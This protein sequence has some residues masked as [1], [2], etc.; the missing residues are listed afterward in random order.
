LWKKGIPFSF[1]KMKRSSDA[2]HGALN[3]V[4][5]SP[6]EDG[7]VLREKIR[8]T[9]KRMAELEKQNEQFRQISR[10][11]EETAR[12]RAMKLA[13][14][15]NALRQTVEILSDETS[16]D[17]ALG[18]VLKV[19]STFM[20]SSLSALWLFNGNNTSHLRLVCADGEII[21]A[22]P[23][24]T[25]RLKREWPLESDPYLKANIGIPRPVLYDVDTHSHLTAREKAQLR[26]QKIEALLVVPLKLGVEIF[27]NFTICF[28]EK[29]IFNGDE[30][31]LLEAFGAQATLACQL[32][33]LAASSQQAAVLEE[34]SRI[35]GEIHDSLAQA[36]TGISMQLEAALLSRNGGEQPYW[37]NVEMAKDMASFGL[38]EARSSVLTLRPTALD[39][40]D[41]SA[42]L[43]RL[44]ERTCIEGKLQCEFVEKG[45]ARELPVELKHEALRIVQEALGNAL[46]HAHPKIIQITLAYDRENI[47][48]TIQDDGV[49]FDR[50]HSSE[51]RGFG[52]E[53]MADRARKLKGTSSIESVK[54]QGTTVKVT[55]PT[56]GSHA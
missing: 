37:K 23:A 33:R 4:G 55:L 22:V 12:Q 14:A 6:P 34:R 31:D 16:L 18:H 32:T 52:L 8:K 42:T 26:K 47:E 28:G 24:N 21:E 19:T 50:G 5:C 36:F 13:E 49:G 17:H 29:R 27:G 48:L 38:A 10:E 53:G 9:K 41:L 39:H 15:N 3:R 40:G 43:K 35:A 7:K 2:Q 46:K 44:T 56:G 11:Q 45:S 25:A 1:K 54:G 30:L 51:K 20:V